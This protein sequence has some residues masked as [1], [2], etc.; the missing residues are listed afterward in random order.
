MTARPSVPFLLAIMGRLVFA[1]STDAGLA[2]SAPSPSAAPD[3]PQELLAQARAAI[4]SERLLGATKT[5]TI[6][7]TKLIHVMDA[8][9]TVPFEIDCQLPDQF[10]WK[11]ASSQ[12][13]L[14][15]GFSRAKLITTSPEGLA[16]VTPQ[17]PPT[18][19]A[20]ASAPSDADQLLVAKSRFTVVTL[21]L[22]AASFGGHAFNLRALPG[23]ATNVP[24]IGLE[25]ADGFGATVI[26]DQ[27]THLVDRMLY[28]SRTA[29]LG[30]VVT[31][32]RYEDYRAIEG[33]QLPHRLSYSFG[34]DAE[35]LRPYFAYETEQIDFN[36]PIAPS[37][38]RRAGRD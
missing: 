17:A 36:R 20:R 38:F 9:Q 14:L 37:V 31:E 11:D 7:G 2:W 3:S 6:R 23:P 34:P 8:E 22:F 21:G 13:D 24:A 29:G 10:V 4:G 18:P 35:H 27:R 26:F 5:F 32:W 19:Q 25:S 12:G 16:F 1:W 30:D 33:R 15:I 28:R